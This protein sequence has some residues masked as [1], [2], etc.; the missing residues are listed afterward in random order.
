LAISIDSVRALSKTFGNTVTS[1]LWRFVE[2]S[3]PST[4]MVALISGHPHPSRRDPSFDPSQPCRHFVPSPAFRQRFGSATEVTL[5]AAVA[6]YCGRQRG[7]LLGE[8]EV[9]L[10]D[11]NGDDHVFHFETF[12]N[13]YEALTLG[14][15][16]RPVS[17]S[18]L[19]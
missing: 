13:R 15:Y 5:F 3:Y 8:A 11:V 2:Q 18:V 4:P 19:V 10:G 12:F 9:I 7:G 1:T 6:S 17:V 14:S 16:L